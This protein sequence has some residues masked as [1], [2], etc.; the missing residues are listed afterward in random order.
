MGGKFGDELTKF[1]SAP[2]DPPSLREYWQ[3]TAELYAIPPRGTHEAAVTALS[4]YAE[5]AQQQNLE[6]FVRDWLDM[7]IAAERFPR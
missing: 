5:E 6:T 7:W 4:L 1:T 3:S 2:L